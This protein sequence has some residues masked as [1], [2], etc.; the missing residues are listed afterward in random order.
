MKARELAGT[1]GANEGALVIAETQTAGRGRGKRQWHSPK[2]GVYLSALL[3]PA[4]EKRL[5][6]LAIVAGVALAQTVKD[7]LPKS[8]DVS[9]KWPNDCLIGWRKVGGILCESL[10][11][12]FFHLCVVG[13]GIN[14]NL[15][16]ADL[17][18]FKD[19]PFSATSFALETG[20]NMDVGKVTQTLI[21]KLFNV[22]SLYQKQGYSSVQFLW[23][24]NCG[25][26]GK[27]VELRDS[28]WRERAASAAD[29]GDSTTGTF[30]GID[31]TGALVLSN[32]KGERRSYHTGEITC[33]WP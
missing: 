1:L 18:P 4:D 32:P 19:N 15:T 27:K 24:M 5:T 28:G 7:C 21:H 33:F 20:G 13:I 3:Y 6:D 22:Y 9:L 17:Q 8:K 31:D 30:L 29:P 10:G 26:L 2:G 14:V 25:M 16:D 11:E 12:E 23:E